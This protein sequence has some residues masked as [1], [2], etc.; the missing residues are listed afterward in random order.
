MIALREGIGD[1]MAEG[2]PRAA[3]HWGRWEEDS[4]SGICAYPYWGGYA[5]HGWDARCDVQW[6]YG[7]IL[8]ERDGNEH[9]GYPGY[10]SRSYVLRKIARE[11]ATFHAIGVISATT[12]RIS[13]CFAQTCCGF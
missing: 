6:G 13:G 12:L 7:S 3:M 2:F 9:G 10:P 1:E 5:E 11:T 4:R 8:A